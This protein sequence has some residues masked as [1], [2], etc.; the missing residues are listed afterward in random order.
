MRCRRT[1]VVIRGKSVDHIQQ[2]LAQGR[3][4]AGSLAP[5]DRPLERARWF[6]SYHSRHHAEH[7]QTHITIQHSFRD[8]NSLR[9][10]KRIHARHS[11]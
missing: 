3:R 4:T 2:W 8:D 7:S 11:R 5:D 1:I 9:F 10:K 6:S